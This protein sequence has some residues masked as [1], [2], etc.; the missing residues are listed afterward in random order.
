MKMPG[1]WTNILLTMLVSLCSSVGYAAGSHSLSA[2][3]DGDRI[4]VK[5][6]DRPVTEYRFSHDQK[7]PYFYPVNGPASGESVTTETSAPYP[8]HHSLFFGCDKVEGRGYPG[9][10]WQEAN[11]AGQILSQGPRIAETGARVVIED[12]C[13]WQRPGREP[14]IR[15]ERRV[16]ISSPSDSA[17]VIDF[18]ITLHPLADVRIHRSNH[19]LFSA[20]MHPGMSVNAGGVLVNAEGDTG[21]GG[22]FGKTSAW[23]A[24]YNTRGGH[25]EGLA[26]VQHPDNRWRP[27]P[28]FTR[29]YGFFSPTPM[30]WLEDG[31]VDLPEGEPLTLRYRVVVFAGNPGDEAI[32]GLL[33]LP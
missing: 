20:R 11:E 27:A 6:G 13:L 4:I 19:S 28:W 33:Q 31:H 2:E 12:T 1:G 22:T 10:Y 5:A 23:C 3:C 32:A 24:Y 26:I 18:E 25:T 7:Y 9:N 29:D 8:H 30:N 16:V 14:V 15:D 21:E 17:R